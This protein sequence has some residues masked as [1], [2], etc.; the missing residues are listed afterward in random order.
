M[1]EC[2]QE[3]LQLPPVTFRRIP[4]IIFVDEMIVLQVVIVLLV[5]CQSQKSNCFE[6]ILDSL[7]KVN[8]GTGFFYKRFEHMK[9]FVVDMI[10]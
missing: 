2:G 5:V 10:I 3:D 7:K 4:C 1:H 6:F 8:L 9:L